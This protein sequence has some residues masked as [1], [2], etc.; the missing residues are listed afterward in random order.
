MNRIMERYNGE[1]KIK[2][3][4]GNKAPGPSPPGKYGEIE[5]KRNNTRSS[6]R[7]M[8]ASIQEKDFMITCI[9]V[10]L[11]R[12]LQSQSRTKIIIGKIKILSRAMLTPAF[13]VIKGG[14]G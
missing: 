11:V 9:S 5:E 7:T 14:D 1:V 8:N 12:R 13:G 2:I 3:R 6:I 10:L 4:I